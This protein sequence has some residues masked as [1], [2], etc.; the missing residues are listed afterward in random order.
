[1]LQ[2]AADQFEH[3]GFPCA[4]IAGVNV[5]AGTTV[6]MR[7]MRMAS[8]VQRDTAVTCQHTASEMSASESAVLHA[9]DVVILH[10]LYRLGLLQPKDGGKPPVEVRHPLIMAEGY[11]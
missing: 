2:T 4:L 7:C 8:D 10:L 3:P 1:V 11:R 9:G 6:H 5:S